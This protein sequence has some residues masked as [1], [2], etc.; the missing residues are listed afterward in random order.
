M[1]TADVSY[2]AREDMALYFDYVVLVDYL[3]APV[4]DYPGRRFKENY[5]WISLAFTKLRAFALTPYEKVIMMDCDMMFKKNTDE[6]FKLNTPAG[7]CSILTKEKDAR[8][9]GKHIPVKLVQ[10]SL[11]S[12]GIRGCCYM[13]EPDASLVET[14]MDSIPKNVQL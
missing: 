12:Y 2:E 6:L 10:Q 3:D 13:I 11:R 9:H 1:H 8:M 7:I 5:A 4:I 14:I